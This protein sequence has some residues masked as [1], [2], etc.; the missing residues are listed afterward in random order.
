MQIAIADENNRIFVWA[1]VIGYERSTTLFDVLNGGWRGCIS[2]DIVTVT[3]TSKS[4]PG[5]IVWNGVAPFGD[6]NEAIPWIQEQVDRCGGR[7]K[8]Y[9]YIPPN[10]PADEMDD[11]PF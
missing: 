8:D 3:N 1:D 6:Y 7:V 9:I 10:L 2:H 4:H 11:I 5:K